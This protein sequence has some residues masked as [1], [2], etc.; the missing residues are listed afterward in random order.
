R[1][2]R[3]FVEVEIWL[4]CRQCAE[5]GAFAFKQREVER[6]DVR[7]VQRQEGGRLG[8]RVHRGVRERQRLQRDRGIRSYRERRVGA[9]WGGVHRQVSRGLGAATNQGIIE[10]GG[11]RLQ[12]DRQVRHCER[13][14]DPIWSLRSDEFRSPGRERVGDRD[15][16]FVKGVVPE[17]LDIFQR[18]FVG[19]LGKPME[20]VPAA[21]HDDIGAVINRPANAGFRC[22]P[23][24]RTLRVSTI[25]QIRTTSRLKSAPSILCSSYC[26]YTDCSPFPTLVRVS[27]S[28][29]AGRASSLYQCSSLTPLGETTTALNSNS[30]VEVYPK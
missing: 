15:R 28:P 18:D 22:I 2:V 21:G 25:G 17:L 19:V 24:Y 26:Q 7:Q 30:P 20:R 16:G 13:C 6:R 5:V 8:E 14:D 27:R 9:C 4:R 3:G 1:A 23:H 11:L 10:L 29:A 12:Q